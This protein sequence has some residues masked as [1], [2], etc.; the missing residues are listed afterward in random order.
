MEMIS[1]ANVAY[2]TGLHAPASAT[3]LRT[4]AVE[5]LRLPG[6]VNAGIALP[7]KGELRP[8]VGATVRD[9]AFS[10][11]PTGTAVSAGAPV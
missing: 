11:P 3:S 5:R 1:T 2:G 4:A 6:M 7:G 8:Q 9:A 10:T